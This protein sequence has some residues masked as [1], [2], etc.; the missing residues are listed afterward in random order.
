MTK[1]LQ[2]IFQSG[3]FYNE[4]NSFWTDFFIN[5]FG[6]LI[7]TLTALWVFTK[8]VRH[9]RKK[10]KEKEDKLIGQKLHYFSSMVDS[11][12]DLTNKQSDHLKLFYEKQRTDVLNIPLLT[13]LPAND[14]KRFSELQNHEEYYHAYLSKFGY[15][16]ELVKEYR[17]YF[18]LIDYLNAQTIQM[19]DMLQKSM[20]FDFERKTKYKEI[21]EKAMDDTADLFN[22]AKQSNQIDDFAN[23]LNESLL[24]FYSGDINYSDLNE[25]QS[26]FIDP[27]KIGIIEKFRNI[28]VAMQL[29]GELKKATFLFSEI[30]FSNASIGDDFEAIFK[31][32]KGASDK[33]QELSIKLNS[34]FINN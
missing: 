28:D 34:T 23:F 12:Y 4:G 3:D 16:S 6:A 17:K 22:K 13:T 32:Y 33:L 14:L 5:V 2:I 25:F 30:K 18:A 10:D 11:I 7:G 19:Q 1:L 21:V 15:T 26:K 20:E 8:Q 24:Q 31:N 27:V 29:A 9:E